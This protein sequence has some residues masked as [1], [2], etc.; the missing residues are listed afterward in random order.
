MS[1][2]LSTCIVGVMCNCLVSDYP[3]GQ[4]FAA[5]IIHD[6]HEEPNR[7]LVKNTYYMNNKCALGVVSSIFLSEIRK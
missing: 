4:V 3:T 2:N 7:D 6:F 1:L 5:F